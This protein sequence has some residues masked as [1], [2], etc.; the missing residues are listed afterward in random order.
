[1]KEKKTFKKKIYK[2]FPVKKTETTTT[3]THNMLSINLNEISIQWI[4]LSTMK[5]RF[6]SM[7]IEMEIFL[8]IHMMKVRIRNTITMA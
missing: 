1:M 8:E 2:S 6:Y 5:L 4:N 3:A 7:E